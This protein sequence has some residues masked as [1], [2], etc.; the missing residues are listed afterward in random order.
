MC[1][2]PRI[3]IQDMNMIVQGAHAGRENVRDDQ[4]EE[5]VSETA[6]YSLYTALL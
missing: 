3:D 4:T 6:P 5:V 2:V 1:G